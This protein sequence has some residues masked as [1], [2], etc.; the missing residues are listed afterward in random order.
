[1]GIIL[2]PSKGKIIKRL[3]LHPYH[4]YADVWLFKQELNIE[5]VVT[6]KE[7]ITDVI[8]A[9]KDVILDMIDKSI[10][11]SKSRVSYLDDLK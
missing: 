1:M 2:D 3:L 6:Q 9:T 11:L 8:W 10:F 4:T 5:I 7:E